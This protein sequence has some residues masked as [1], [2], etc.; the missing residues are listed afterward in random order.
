[1]QF[2]KDWHLMLIVAG[3]IAAD[4]VV[5]SVVTGL[6]SSVR[7]SVHSIPD[8]ERPD[9]IN[10]CTVYSWSLKNWYYVYM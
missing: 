10:V 8:K 6:G 1:M 9:T 2:V 3:F 5:L 4:V 7:Y